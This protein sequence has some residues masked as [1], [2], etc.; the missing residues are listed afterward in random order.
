VLLLKALEI[1]TTTAVNLHSS[2]NANRHAAAL[3]LSLVARP[4][5]NFLSAFVVY[6]VLNCADGPYQCIDRG[7]P[8]HLILD[9]SFSTVLNQGAMEQQMSLVK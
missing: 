5:L 2:K 1:N 8:P 7:R 9:G 3:S 6:K 4:L